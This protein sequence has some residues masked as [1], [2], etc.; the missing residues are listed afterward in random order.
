MR[1]IVLK[2]SISL[3]TVVLALSLMTLPASADQPSGVLDD[4]SIVATL[5]IN[6]VEGRSLC[7][8]REL[9]ESLETIPVVT[10]V[11]SHCT[12]EAECGNHPSVSCE[13]TTTCTAVDQDCFSGERGYVQCDSSKVNCPVCDCHTHC[14]SCFRMELDKVDACGC[15]CFGYSSACEDSLVWDCTW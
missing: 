8:A 12:A 7:A 5:N 2:C 1:D 13:G 6:R 15:R 11:Y 4:E 14:E 9:T 10:G 3:G